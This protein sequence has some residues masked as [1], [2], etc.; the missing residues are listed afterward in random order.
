[1]DSLDILVVTF[2]CGRQLVRPELFA[3]HLSNAISQSSKPDII[4]LSLQEI[5]PIAYSFLGGSYLVPYLH[6][7]R[8]AV[9]LVE[10][11]IGEK[12]YVHVV[13]KNV[14]MTACMIFVREKHKS[15]VQWIETSG[16]GVG[17]QEMGN[18]G[19]VGVTLGY[20]TAPAE[21]TL[22]FTFVAAHLA[23]ME[24]AVDRRNEDWRNIVRGLVFA[25]P[26]NRN[27]FATAT[28]GPTTT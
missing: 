13:T 3:R 22:E 21:K 2:N 23:P 25:P 14:G 5:A 19:A 9:Y 12:K 17:L 6:R 7:F 18:K 10:E 26:N 15:K 24:D 8:H 28:N 16:V 1:M 11:T 27:P 4:A 20:N